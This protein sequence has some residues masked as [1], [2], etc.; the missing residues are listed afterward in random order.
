MKSWVEGDGN[1]R[2]QC[3]V[4]I[5][6][7][8]DGIPFVYEDPL[9]SEGSQFFWIDGETDPSTYWWTE[10]NMA[11]DCNRIGF[12]PAELQKLHPGGCGEA[13]HLRKI[14]PLEGENLPV[15]NLDEV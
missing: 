9:E 14:I 2:I 6:G 5:E 3:R 15:L 1:V 12:M 8:Y 11:C 4:R 10:G 13:I 7:E